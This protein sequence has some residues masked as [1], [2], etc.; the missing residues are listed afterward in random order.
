MIITLNFYWVDCL[1]PLLYPTVWN[2][3]TPSPHSAQFSAFTS[4]GQVSQLCLDLGGVARYR[5]PAALSPLVTKAICFW[6]APC[7][8]SVGPSVVVE[9]TTMGVL[10][11]RAAL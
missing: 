4:P 11:G 10:N 3:T 9:L 7:M 5:G 6:G 2:I 1:S 8:D